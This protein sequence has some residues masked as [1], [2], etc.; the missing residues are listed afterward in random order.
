[1]DAI[2]K[3][4]PPE[5]SKLGHDPILR[6]PTRGLR[7]SPEN[8]ELYKPVDSSDRAVIELANSITENGI[9]EPLVVTQDGYIISGHRR[10]A[11][12]LLAGLLSVP[13]RVQHLAREN[14]LDGF[15]RLLREHNRQRIKTHAELLREAVVDVDRDEAYQAMI[16]HRQSQ[17]QP[18]V[19][20]S[21]RI[22]GKV[23]RAKIS[24]AKRPMLNTIRRI[25]ADRRKF[26]PLS[27]RQVH[28]AL[29]NDPPLK[30]ASKPDSTYTNDNNSYKAL[31]DLAI[32]ARL[33]GELPM[34]A[35][36]DETRPMETWD[37][38]ASVEGFIHRE[39][40]WMFR[41]FRRDLMQSQPDH[42]E[43]FGE[44]N[45]ILSI[46]RPIAERYTIPM[47]VGRGYTSL[48]PRDKINKRYIKSGKRNLVLLVLSDHD[49]EGENIP[50]A[51][52][53][54]MRD[55]FGIEN[56]KAFKVGL[57]AD[58][59]RDYKLPTTL[60]AKKTSSRYKGYTRKHGT[61]VYELE[62]LTPERLQE[63]L[64]KAI[65]SVIDTE[66]FNAELDAERDDAGQLQGMRRAARIALG[67]YD[68]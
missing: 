64:V 45:T 43:I 48:P 36:D 14:D 60:K 46:I 56:V 66:A 17:R 22:T 1:M 59:V 5:K 38:F 34:H 24:K 44:K 19:G 6:L 28:Y 65:D 2:R 35:I 50:H 26:W 4:E 47:T 8:D 40:E 15:I 68:D 58:Q 57:T 52:A 25:L 51:L 55:D 12:A 13:C 27:V 29:L 18:D 23:M 20:D 21:I 31:V 10:H 67:R 61:D 62:A 37:I 63:A 42:I 9:L 30:H 7:P 53:R 11:A 33:A 16:E 3:D 39:L 49:P 41:N 32:R 54:S